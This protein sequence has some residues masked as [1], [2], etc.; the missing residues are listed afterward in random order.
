VVNNRAALA[1]LHGIS[2]AR[3]TQV[4]AL[5]RLHTDVVGFVR[6]VSSPW[7]PFSWARDIC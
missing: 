5:L 2:L 6:D 3:V 4:M 1:R 7:H